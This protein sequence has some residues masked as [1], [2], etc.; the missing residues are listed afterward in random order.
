MGFDTSWVL[1]TFCRLAWTIEKP[2]DFDLLYDCKY[3]DFFLGDD[4]LVTWETVTGNSHEL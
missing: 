3:R 4:V 1:E 2:F